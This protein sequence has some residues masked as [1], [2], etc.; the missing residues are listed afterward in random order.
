MKE[1]AGRP[2]AARQQRQAADRLRQIADDLASDTGQSEVPGRE[3]QDDDR[4]VAPEGRGTPG[5]AGGNRTGAGSQLGPERAEST[6]PAGSFT[7]EDVAGPRAREPVGGGRV[8]G[9]RPSDPSAQEATI[10]PVTPARL[11]EAAAGAERAIEQQSVPDRRSELVRR[12]FRRYAERAQTPGT[13]P[14]A[15]SERPASEPPPKP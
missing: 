10:P 6:L 3:G 7:I 1:A 12:V 15:A 9:E 4:P 13:A 8:A 14:G 2:D 5:A 11:Q